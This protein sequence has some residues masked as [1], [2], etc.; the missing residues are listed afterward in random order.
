MTTLEDKETLA[1]TESQRAELCSFV[2]LAGEPISHYW[3]MKTFIHHNPLHGLEHYHFEK[4]I[5]KAER[6][7]GGRGY[8]PNEYY[9]EY[10]N[11]GRITDKALDEV[12]KDVSKDTAIEIGEKKISHQEFLKTI[13]LNGSGEV[14][15]DVASAVLQSSCNQSE[16]NEL[17]EK[18]QSLSRNKERKESLQDYAI[19]EQENLAEQ[20]T[21][22]EWCD[23]SL[24]TQVQHQINNE[25]IKW[26]GGFLD[27]GHANWSMPLREKTF[28][29]GW[30]ELAQEDAS[31][32]LLGISDWKN[33]IK[34]LPDRPE[35]AILECMSMLSIPKNL[36]I[37]YFTLH[38]GQLAGWT[39]F[40]KWRSEQVDYEWQSAYPIDLI[41]Y[42]AVR[43][44]YERELVGL[45]CRSK[46]AIP[47]TYTSIR[48]YLNNFSVGYGL[49]KDYQ[50]NGL[51]EE[52]ERVTD[53]WRELRAAG[54]F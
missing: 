3:P 42:L 53:A 7:L 24:G 46:L 2:K 4:A 6:F 34:N 17:I 47:G 36:W 39:G 54:E 31:G 43:V 5:K 1:P 32:S 8:L 35:D 9:R 22:A 11:Q 29:G 44:F 14:A 52:M 41:K 30:K 33:K 51:P 40:L 37:D 45:A 20:Y 50:T 18:F 49:Y 21:L 27:E 38:L 19:C 48:A 12:L 15:T 16:L 10:F 13:L 26:V 28:Y 23:K 25:V